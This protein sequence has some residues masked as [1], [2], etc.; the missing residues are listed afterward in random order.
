MYPC[1]LLKEGPQKKKKKDQRYPSIKF[2][3]FTDSKVS[4][5]GVMKRWTEKTH[6]LSMGRNCTSKVTYSQF[7]NDESKAGSI[8]QIS[9]HHVD[10][11]QPKG[12]D[13]NIKARRLSKCQYL[14]SSR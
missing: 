12:T 4:E 3:S 13:G 10:R 6:L 9:A 14:R 11:P 2:D 1:W 7:M 5:G 8:W